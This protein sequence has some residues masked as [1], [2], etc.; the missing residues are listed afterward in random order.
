M[1][2]TSLKKYSVHSKNNRRIRFPFYL[3]PMSRL[4]KGYLSKL[5]ELV[6]EGGFM[7][8]YERG[9]FKSGYCILKENRLVL[10]NNFLPLDGRI[11]TMMDLALNLELQEENLSVKSRRLLAEIREEKR[12][13][14]PEIQFESSKE[15]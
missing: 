13:A 4:T 9:N 15:D 14:Q 10:I 5:E 11:N 12:P 6:S 7:V 8:R 1:L 3:C 2:I